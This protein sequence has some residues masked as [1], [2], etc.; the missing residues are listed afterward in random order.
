MQQAIDFAMLLQSG[1]L[2]LKLNEVEKGTMSPTLGQDA[3]QGGIIAGIIGLALVLAFMCAYYRGLGVVASVSLFIYALLLLYAIAGMPMFFSL[4][5]IPKAQPTL[6]SIAGIIL[7]IGMAVDAN[8][9]IYER[10]KDEYRIGK[11]LELSIKVGFKRAFSAI[12]DSNVTTLFAAIVLLWLGTGSIKGF[13]IVLLYGIIISVFC[14]MV[15]T[16]AILAL[17][18]RITEK[19]SF[20]GL[21]EGRRD[22]PPR[23]NEKRV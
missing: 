1:S 23:R 14:A 12:L 19:P 13:A 3:L 5:I 15:V 11:S 17:I 10:I 6:P 7:S 21:K 16:R 8:V 18:V 22:C 20:F 4:P 9:I 2:P